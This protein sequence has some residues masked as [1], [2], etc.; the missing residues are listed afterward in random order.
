MASIIIHQHRVFMKISSKTTSRSHNHHLILKVPL[1]SMPDS[2][3]QSTCHPRTVTKAQEAMEFIRGCHDMEADLVIATMNFHRTKRVSN[4]SRCQAVHR[5]HQL[6]AINNQAQANGTF[7]L[8]IHIIRTSIPLT[9]TRQHWVT[10]I[11]DTI[12]SRTS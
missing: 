6:P 3:N 10:H 11:T 7:H 1:S 8:T 9:I 12:T 2:V 5:Q 4:S